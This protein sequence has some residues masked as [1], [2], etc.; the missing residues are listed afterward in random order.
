MSV[1]I[2]VVPLLGWR[3]LRH[4]RY[5][6]PVMSYSAPSGLTIGTSQISRWFTRRVM[7]ASVP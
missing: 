5:V 6:V 3:F 1:P 2:A 4:A 7:A